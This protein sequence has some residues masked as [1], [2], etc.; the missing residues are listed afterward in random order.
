MNPAQVMNLGQLL[1]Q[2]A[3]QFPDHIGLIHAD[4][5]WTW[6]EIDARVDA[7]VSAL[8]AMGLKPGDAILVQSRQQPAD[9]RELL[10]RV[11]PGLR[12]G[13][14]E[15]SAHAAGGGL[16]GASSG[17]VAMIAEDILLRMWARCVP[18][19][20]HWR[21]WCGW[22]RRQPSDPGS[23]AKGGA[24]SLGQPRSATSRLRSTGAAAPGPSRPA[25]H[26]HG[27]PAAVVLLHLRHH[28]P[29]QGG[30]AH[31]RAN[32]FCGG[33]PPGR[34][35]PRHDRERPLHRRGPAIARRWRARAA[36]RGARA[37]PPC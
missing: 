6:R 9:V 12:V 1:A 2:T 28:R 22:A 31:A 27:R 24:Q 11:S 34:P 16:P 23:G 4:R 36:E 26:R 19:R 33:Q 14:D 21:E 37:R 15:L 25:R 18:L 20:P 32:G 30:R 13:A 8:R 35:D 5:Q 29:A 7:M 3:R 17:A 10:G